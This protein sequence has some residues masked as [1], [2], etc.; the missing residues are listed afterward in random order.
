MPFWTVCTKRA[1]AWT[2]VEAGSRLRGRLVQARLPPSERHR[3]GGP[4]Q[5]TELQIALAAEA[6]KAYDGLIAGGDRFA[7][8]QLRA[9]DSRVYT[10]R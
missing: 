6:G 10:A 7:R 5:F 4:H 3:A 8:W 1:S 2:S 9:Q